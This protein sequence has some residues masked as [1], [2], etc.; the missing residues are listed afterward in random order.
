MIMKKLICLLALVL[1]FSVTC[2]G[3]LIAPKGLYVG[4]GITAVSGTHV[5]KIDSICLI[6]GKIYAFVAGDSTAFADLAED[7][8]L[9]NTFIDAY[10]TPLSTGNITANVGITSGMLSTRI[11]YSGN[12][13]INISSNPQII[14]GTNGQ[15]ITIVGSSDTNTLTLDDADGLSLSAQCV[16]GIGDSITLM[17]SSALDLWVEISRSN[18]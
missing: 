11:Y 1:G 7:V 8:V 4:R 10:N 9:Y 18:N 3:Q 5:T 6:N 12:S 2:F 15:I 14:D 17:Y 16:L 13:A